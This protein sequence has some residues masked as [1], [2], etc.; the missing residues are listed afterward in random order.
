MKNWAGRRPLRCARLAKTAERRQPVW[1][2]V[3]P[4][5][6]LSRRGSLITCSLGW[7]VLAPC[8]WLF[9]VALFPR[10][11]SGATPTVCHL[12]LLT[13]PAPAGHS[14]P[15]FVMGSQ[16]CAPDQ[17]GCRTTTSETTGLPYVIINCENAHDR[18]ASRVFPSVGLG[19]QH[20]AP[21]QLRSGRMLKA[22][23][24][25]PGLRCPI[26]WIDVGPEGSDSSQVNISS[27]GEPNAF[28]TSGAPS[29]GYTGPCFTR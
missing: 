1:E 26:C 4:P 20:P 3:A 15:V 2:G 25:A 21:L 29:T 14:S 13:Y 6:H 12:V 17:Q 24:A 22:L 28:A 8:N 16:C 5:R 23:G 18:D 19:G 11:D 7:L 27:S 10:A 9:G